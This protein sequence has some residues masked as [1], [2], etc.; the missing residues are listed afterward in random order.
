VN[1]AEGRTPS[2]SLLNFERLEPGAELGR[3]TICVGEDKLQTWHAL[4]P[5]SM[6]GDGAVPPGILAVLMMR[7]FAAEVTCRLTGYGVVGHDLR[8][9]AQPVERG[10]TL[11]VTFH[12]LDKARRLDGLRIEVEAVMHTDS[13]ALVFEGEISLLRPASAG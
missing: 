4:F 1:T 3:A 7:A 5:G 12:C 9:G 10:T 6:S 13:G 11:V 8:W 2:R